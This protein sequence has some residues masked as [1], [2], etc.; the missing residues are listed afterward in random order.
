[1]EETRFQI[2]AELIEALNDLHNN[3]AEELQLLDDELDRIVVEKRGG[4]GYTH[5]YIAVKKLL[6][7]I[8][9]LLCLYGLSIVSLFDDEYIVTVLSHASGGYFISRAYIGKDTDSAQWRAGRFTILR[10]T[11]VLGLLNIDDGTPDND[12]MEA[13]T[14]IY[15]K[16]Q[17]EVQDKK[18]IEITENVVKA[19]KNKEVKPV[20]PKKES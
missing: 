18:G 11:A 7:R 2:T 10:R 19:I 14:A 16:T 8:N 3:H 17:N 9:P 4:G 5:Y 15:G 12:G 20:K 6:D 1:M 13:T